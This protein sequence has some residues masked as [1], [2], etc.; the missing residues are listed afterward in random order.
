MLDEFVWLIKGDDSY[1]NYLAKKWRTVISVKMK[2][3]DV[4]FCLSKN[5]QFVTDEEKTKL[6]TPICVNN[7][8]YKD[9]LVVLDEDE[10]AGFVW[11]QKRCFCISRKM[12]DDFSKSELSFFSGRKVN[13][14]SASKL[15]SENAI[16]VKY[17]S[18]VTIVLLNLFAVLL[19]AAGVY[20][21]LF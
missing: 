18:F 16:V 4:Y 8:E 19:F 6:L 13:I 21:W 2:N 12:I 7:D 5:K 9:C 17:S 11:S 1:R 10:Q 3:G 20:V 14:K 15:V